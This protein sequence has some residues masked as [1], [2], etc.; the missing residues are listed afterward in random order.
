VYST[1]VISCK[2]TINPKNPAS[3]ANEVLISNY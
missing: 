3:T 1:R 2:R